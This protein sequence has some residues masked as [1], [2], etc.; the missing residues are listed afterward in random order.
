M[1]SAPP[2]GIVL[3]RH[4]DRPRGTPVVWFRRSV[5]SVL[6]VLLGVALYGAFGQ[7]PRADTSEAPEAT[8]TVSAPTSLRG[9][10]FFQGRFTIEA[11]ERVGHAT[12]V[13]DEG[14]TEQ[15]SINTIEP[16]PASE[17]SRDGRLALDFGP[18]E[19]GEKLVAYLQFQVN[20]TNIGRRTQGVELLDGER[21]IAS[22]DR[23]V[24]VYP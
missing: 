3:A 15:L 17:E 4:R 24:T 14:W 11:R 2:D 8:L 20:P 1:A 13:L 22:I 6:V 7:R 5:V 10:I 19:P 16:S 12:L 23:T 18:L 9:G 21:L